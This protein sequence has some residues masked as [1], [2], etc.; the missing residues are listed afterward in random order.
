MTAVQTRKTDRIGHL[1]HSVTRRA[2][3]IPASPTSTTKEVQTGTLISF[4]IF[5]RRARLLTDGTFCRRRLM[6]LRDSRLIPQSSSSP[7]ADIRG[8]TFRGFFVDCEFY[9]APECGEK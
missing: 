9:R 5:L 1:E 6:A 8:S 3:V 2:D 7:V 4:P